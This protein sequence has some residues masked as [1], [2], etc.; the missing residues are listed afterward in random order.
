MRVEN[1]QWQLPTQAPNSIFEKYICIF[2]NPLIKGQHWVGN[3]T[4]TETYDNVNFAGFC[5]KEGS[6]TMKPSAS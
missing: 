3:K 5:L 4:H 1:A 2:S 6:N